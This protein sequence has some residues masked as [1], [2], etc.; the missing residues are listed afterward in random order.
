MPQRATSTS[1][2][3]GQS[4]NPKGRAKRSNEEALLAAMRVAV[5]KADWV[6]IT[7]KAVAD[8]KQGNG[9]ARKWLS[10]YLLG[11]PIQRTEITGEEGG[12]LRIVVEYADD[13]NST[14]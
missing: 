10:D 2:K 12:A 14:S 9:F 11:P 4:G 7:M 5:T 8:A 1:F 6:D 3:P 13:S